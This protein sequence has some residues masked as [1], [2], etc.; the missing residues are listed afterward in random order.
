MKNASRA[1]L[2]FF[3]GTAEKRQPRL[4]SGDRATTYSARNVSFIF[5]LGYVSI[6]ASMEMLFAVYRRHA[7]A[8]FW[9]RPLPEFFPANAARAITRNSN[10][11]R[12]KEN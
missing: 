12:D 10:S 6:T 5:L 7:A 1:H 9:K 4:L 3:E 11:A 2:G 8:G